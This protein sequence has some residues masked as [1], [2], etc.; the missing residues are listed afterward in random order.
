MTVYGKQIVYIFYGTIFRT[1]QEFI[2]FVFEERDEGWREESEGDSWNGGGGPDCHWQP[3]L[4]I[5]CPS[6]ADVCLNCLAG[7]AS[8][9]M[10]LPEIG[11]ACCYILAD[12]CNGCITQRCMHNSRTV[13]Y[14]VSQLQFLACLNNIGFLKKRKACKDKIFFLMQPS[15]RKIHRYV[16]PPS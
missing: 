1:I 10:M 13:S 15:Q 2:S 12:F 4:N 14:N 7:A 9:P 6:L 8:S 16:A 5:P 3:G 11:T